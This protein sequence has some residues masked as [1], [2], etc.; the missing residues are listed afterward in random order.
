MLC[1]HG[2]DVLG[3]CCKDAV[4]EVRPDRAEI[5]FLNAA[6]DQ[7]ERHLGPLQEGFDFEAGIVSANCVHGGGQARTLQVRARQARHVLRA[8]SAHCA[9]GGGAEGRAQAGAEGLAGAR[10]RSE[11]L[12]AWPTLGE[13][14]VDVPDDDRN[15]DQANE[16]AKGATAEIAMVAPIAGLTRGKAVA[17][18]R[19][20]AAARTAE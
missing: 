5:I 17:G 16:V 9:T 14:T 4:I 2:L 8:S 19:M 12:Q 6:F 7:K 3:D 18:P 15:D 11:S 13:A 1:G 20:S 10:H